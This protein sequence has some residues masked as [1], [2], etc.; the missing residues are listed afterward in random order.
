[1]TRKEVV[2]HEKELHSH[3]IQA[4]EVGDERKKEEIMAE[5]NRN[6]EQRRFAKKR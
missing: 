5:L 2:R 3:Y 6:I 1:M 4:H